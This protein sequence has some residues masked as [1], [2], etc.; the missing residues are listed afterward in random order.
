[1]RRDPRREQYKMNPLTLKFQR[2]QAKQTEA[3]QAQ[4][5]FLK[6]AYKGTSPTTPAGEIAALQRYSTN[7]EKLKAEILREH[8]QNSHY[9]GALY[10]INKELDST[11]TEI[12]RKQI[13]QLQANR[14][15]L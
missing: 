11:A 12:V 15:N 1:M 14:L 13:D 6:R 9:Q 2:K 4:E 7:L 5:E 3:E 10:W 8:G